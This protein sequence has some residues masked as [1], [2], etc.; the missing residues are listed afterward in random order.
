VQPRAGYFARDD[1]TG[2]LGNAVL[3][4]LDPLVR[5]RG[6]SFRRC[7]LIRRARAS[8]HDLESEHLAQRL[9]ARGEL[10]LARFAG[11]AHSPSR[12]V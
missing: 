2:F 9:P 7:T 4:K 11:V 6:Y 12:V 1:A 10:L 3:D 8:R 5:L